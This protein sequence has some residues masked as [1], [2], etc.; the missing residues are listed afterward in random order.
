M[1]DCKDHDAS[2]FL[3]MELSQCLD[4]LDNIPLTA[5][6]WQGGE[7]SN[8]FSYIAQIQGRKLLRSME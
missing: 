1:L 6:D 2:S 3:L 8:S 7:N 5:E 4:S